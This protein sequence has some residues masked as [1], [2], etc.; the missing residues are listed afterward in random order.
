MVTVAALVIV[1][2]PVPDVVGGLVL[3][4]CAK[5]RLQ[6][7]SFVTGEPAPVLIWEQSEHLPAL[8]AAFFGSLEPITPLLRNLLAARTS[9]SRHSL[10]FHE[11]F[12]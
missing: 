9:N 4:E 2:V 10:P 5:E 3:A 12:G 1:G 7:V 8:P 6:R 11:P